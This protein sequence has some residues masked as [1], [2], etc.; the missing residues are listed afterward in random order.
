MA[1][2]SCQTH[3]SV[4]SDPY[5]LLANFIL[6]SHNGPSTFGSSNSRFVQV[7]DFSCVQIR[8]P[9]RKGYK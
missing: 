7:R 4:L 6:D 8:A 2:V 1:Q 3:P 9:I 5:G